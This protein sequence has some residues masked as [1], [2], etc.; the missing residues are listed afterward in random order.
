MVSVM[1]AASWTDEQL[2]VTIWVSFTFGPLLYLGLREV[3]VRCLRRTR[4]AAA[5]LVSLADAGILQ[6]RQETVDDYAGVWSGGVRCDLDGDSSTEE[7]PT[8]G[9][10]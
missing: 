7:R 6:A 10:D 5:A 8:R 9:R 1:T 3:I 4:V 2:A